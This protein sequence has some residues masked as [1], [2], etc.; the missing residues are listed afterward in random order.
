MAF[1]RS[2]CAALVE[3]AAAFGRPQWRQHAVSRLPSQPSSAVTSDRV[4]TSRFAVSLSEAESRSVLDERALVCGR[5][6]FGWYFP[7]RVAQ[8]RARARY[9]GNRHYAHIHSAACTSIWLPRV[10][11]SRSDHNIQNF[12][13]GIDSAP[14][15]DQATI[16]LRSF[17]RE[18]PILQAR[19]GH[20]KEFRLSERCRRDMIA[21][22]SSLCDP[23]RTEAKAFRCDAQRTHHSMIC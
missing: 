12:A 8:L 11:S 10:C 13:L 20:T 7:F 4:S 22:S 23:T 19:Q 14:K 18:N 9:T 17:R 6:I 15:V 16:D 2:R 1:F 5:H 21:T 3:S